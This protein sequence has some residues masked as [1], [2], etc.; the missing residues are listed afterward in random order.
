MN[1]HFFQ[2]HIS[3][4]CHM[5]I[6]EI[7]AEDRNPV[8]YFAYGMLTDPNQMGEATKVGPATLKNFEF[9]L[10]Q[11][12]NLN[13]KSGAEVQGA[14]WQVSRTFMGHL[15]RVE[16]YPSMYD[17]KQVPVYHNGQKIPAYAYF[18]TPLTRSYMQGTIPSKRYIQML[19]RGYKHFGLPLNQIKFAMDT[20]LAHSNKPQRKQKIDK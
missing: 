2:G 9:E 15:D 10:L 4:G 13:A 3:Q 5:K 17:R 14:L 8:Y 11:F 18:L 12:A 16:G 7:L 6:N 1:G 20:A 19:I